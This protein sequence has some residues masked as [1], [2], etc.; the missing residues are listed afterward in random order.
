MSEATARAG[1]AMTFVG[2]GARGDQQACCG[3]RDERQF[4]EVLAGVKVGQ[5]IEFD[6]TVRGMQAE[7]TAVKRRRT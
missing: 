4:H 3:L 5:T 7:V 6:T 2:E 1:Q